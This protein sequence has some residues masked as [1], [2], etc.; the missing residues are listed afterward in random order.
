MFVVFEGLDGA[1]TTTQLKRVSDRLEA[2]GYRTLITAEPS[3]GNIGKYIR[4][5]LTKEESADKQTLALLFAADRLDHN[6]NVLKPALEQGTIVLCDRYVISSLVY[7]GVDCSDEWVKAINSQAI[8][9][10]LTLY[11]SVTTEEA[12][13]RRNHRGGKTELFEENSFLS[14]VKDRYDKFS[15]SDPNTCVIDAMQSIEQITNDCVN[16]ILNK[17]SLKGE[18]L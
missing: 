4:K 9:S 18:Q 11:F 16:A 13:N 12:F 5:I 8:N 10:D 1:G 14:M 3:D 2:L 15:E 17:L 6:C 7:Q